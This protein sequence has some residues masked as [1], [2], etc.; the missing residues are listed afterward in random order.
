[1]RGCISVGLAV[2]SLAGF[3]ALNLFAQT[4]PPETVYIN[5]NIHTLDPARSVRGATCCD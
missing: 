5:A 1:M 4:P 3:G 2:L